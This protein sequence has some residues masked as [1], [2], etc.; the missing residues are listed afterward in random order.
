MNLLGKTLTLL[1]LF[2]A[3]AQAQIQTFSAGETVGSTMAKL[4]ANFSELTITSG[5]ANSDLD[6]SSYDITDASD[7]TILTNLLIGGTQT[8]INHMSVQIQGRSFAQQAGAHLIPSNYGPDY[9]AYA[10][11]LMNA[12]DSHIILYSKDEGGHGSS[13]VLGETTNGVVSGVWILAKAATSGGH[14]GKF[15]IRRYNDNEWAGNQEA[16]FFITT[17]NLVTIG[18]NFTD[19]LGMLVHGEM[20]SDTARIKATSL[21]T[22]YQVP[23]QYTGNLGANVTVEGQDSLVEIVSTPEGSWGSRLGFVEMT[24]TTDSNMVNQWVIMRKTADRDLQFIYDT[25][26]NPESDVALL[27]LRNDYWVDI[28]GDLDVSEHVDI[29][30]IIERSAAGNVTAST[31]QSQGN[32]VLSLE[33]NNVATVANPN[34][35][36]TLYG[37]LPGRACFIKNSGANTLQIFPSSGDDLG[38]GLNASTTLAAGAH[39][40]FI[41]YD[42]TTW[43]QEY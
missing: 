36:V 40:R 33:I 31:T 6:M 19:K 35:V 39:T 25:N 26:G 17:N 41:T 9:D 34:D 30:G 32:G 2:S 8:N 21:G 28:N 5:V 1:I 42:S 22:E 20:E 29:A 16:P 15:Y 43:V 38:A 13:L 11:L 14:D 27:S 10:T 7:V 4:N 37:A 3:S 23:S 12:E 24:S 18:Q